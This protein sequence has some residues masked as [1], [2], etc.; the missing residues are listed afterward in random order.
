MV[1]AQKE[2]KSYQKV[3]SQND[4]ITSVDFETV[5][6]LK[7]HISR[8]EISVNNLSLEKNDL[9][10]KVCVLEKG[11]DITTRDLQN[12]IECLQVEIELLRSENDQFLQPQNLKQKIQYHA[13]VKQENN[14]LREDLHVLR[15]E[16]GRLQQTSTTLTRF[17]VDLRTYLL[18][19]SKESDSLELHSLVSTLVHMIQTVA[20]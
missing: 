15:E 2:L 5:A 18:S 11:N 3:T 7:D 12:E 6:C 10:A 19:R 20:P 4:R 8:L 1:Q 13:K 9:M 16:L 14:E 17:M